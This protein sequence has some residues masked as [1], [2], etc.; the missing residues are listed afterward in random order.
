MT[1]RFFL[2]NLGALLAA[3]VGVAAPQPDYAILNEVFG[4]PVWA[5]ENLWDDA[6]ADVARRL[7]WPLES[8]TSTDAS[9]RL[10][11][12]AGASLLGARPHSLALYGRAGA[13]SRVSMVF[14]NKGDVDGSKEMGS[15]YRKQIT[16]DA[17]TIEERL[18]KALGPAKTAQY[19]QGSKTRE[20][21]ERWDWNGHAILLA[22]PREEYV[23]VR[24]LPTAEADTTGVAR[25]SD[26][27]MGARLLAR[28]ERRPNGDVVLKDMPMVDQGPKGYCLPATWERVLRYMDI[29]AD[30]YVLAMAAQ[31]GVGGGTTTTAMA[32]AVTQSL[33]RSGRRLVTSGGRITTASMARFIDRGLPVMWGIYFVAPLDLAITKRSGERRDVTDWKAY[34]ESLKPW[35]KAARQILTRR[36]DGHM[37]M[38]V[39]YNAATGE[40]AISDSWG[41][42]YRERWITV[43]EANAISGGDFTIV[44]R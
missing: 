37:C 21:V 18:E 22:A 28:V 12:G 38:I 29:S 4:V 31:T 14:A 13:A 25:I 16:A 30:M 24:I 42:Q 23:A 27:E 41:P 2:G 26:T 44:G 10:Y 8:R 32:G 36:E 3:G 9:F 19:G 7:G 39:G 1:W 6:D 43:E 15:D 40:I 5:D 34:A 11:P 35:R 20:R 33:A 17:R